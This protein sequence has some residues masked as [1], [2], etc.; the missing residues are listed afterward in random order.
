VSPKNAPPISFVVV[1]FL[2][3]VVMVDTKSLIESRSFW[4]ALLT[5]VALVATTLHVS[6]LAAWAADP[7]TIDAIMNV[8][9]MFGAAGAIVF[10][11]RATSRTVSVLP[12]DS[13]PGP[14][15][16]LAA[17]CSLPLVAATG[18]PSVRL[19]MGA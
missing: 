11:F 7:K 14:G 19:V 17:L 18:S 1:C 15:K 13:G 10:R 9:A 6:D 12:T 4:S 2:R 5:L 16:A 3:G 8:L